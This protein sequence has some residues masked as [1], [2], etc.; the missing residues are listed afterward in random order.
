MGLFRADDLHLAETISRLDYCNPFL[1]E[2][3]ELERE[4]LGPEFEGYEQFLHARPETRDDIEMN[5]VRIMNKVGGLLERARAKLASGHALSTRD[6]T[7]YEDVALFYL[8]HR[9]HM[10]FRRWIAVAT[11]EGKS[12]RIDF[13]ED[14]EEAAH[15]QLAIPGVKFFENEPL[16]HVFAFFFQLN[17]AF[18]HIYQNLV[19]GSAAAAELRGRIWQSIFTHDLKRYRHVLYSRMGDIATLIIGPSGTGKEL[20][21]RAIGLSRYIPFD[22]RN[23]QFKPDFTQVFHPLNLSALSPTTIES[24]L[25][26]HKQG[27]FTGAVKDR[28]GWF[29]LCPREGTVFLDE[30]GELD[31]IIQVKLLR[32]L[33]SRT[34]QRLG[35]TQTHVFPGKLVAATN[36]DLQKAIEAKAFRSDMYYRLCADI[37]VTPSLQQML[38]GKLDEMRGLVRYIAEQIAGEEGDALTDEVMSWIEKEIGLDYAWPGNF[39]ELE[40]CVKNVLI[41]R[42]YH[43]GKKTRND[44]DL[45][46][47]I[48]DG[49]L[50]E[51]EILERYTRLVYELTGRNL[52]ETARRLGIDRRTV[53]SRVKD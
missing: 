8:Y 35:D 27:A 11:R 3:L 46:A 20:V 24:E 25:F 2:R 21:A 13:Y 14:F 30:I 50:S 49:A 10:Q 32:V 53:R 40:Q 5:V 16:E 9:F 36:R 33:Q 43:P 15:E 37:I 19:G 45:A 44:A 23:R 52:S 48:E 29:E 34:F 51:S 42:E 41:R 12:S 1:A 31:P 18:V 47:A 4:A 6:K 28:Q 39:R 26:G 7:L 38:D 22:V 17:R